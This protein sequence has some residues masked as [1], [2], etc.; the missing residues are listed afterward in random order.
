MPLVSWCAIV[1]LLVWV[2]FELVLRRRA[3]E[4]TASWHGDT[5]DRGS[6]RL[7]LAAYVLSGVLVTVFSVLDLGELPTAPRWIGVALIAAGLALRGRAMQVLGRDYTRTLRVADEQQVV[8]AG[9][10]RL[11]RHPGYAGSLL[12]WIGYALGTGSW[13]ALLLVA[14]LLF[15]AYTWRITAEEAALTET[16][17]L[18]YR[19]YQARTRRLVPF[20][21]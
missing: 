7:L 4:D 14:V 21:Y 9:P 11:I 6:T 15:A 20:V 19:D 17:C 8:T 3:D 5:A 13:I 16:L 2:G 18:P 12:V 1:G 10:Y